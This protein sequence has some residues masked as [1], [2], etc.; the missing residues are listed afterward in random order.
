MAVGLRDFDHPVDL[1]SRLGQF[2][3]QRIPVHQVER[4]AVVGLLE[5]PSES[6]TCRSR[7]TVSEVSSNSTAT[8][9]L[10]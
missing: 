7:T 10:A 2:G 5:R 9:R 1:Q 8:G 4:D 3:G 6:T